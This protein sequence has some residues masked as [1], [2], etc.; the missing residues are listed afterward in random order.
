MA[1]KQPN[2]LFI[3]VDEMHLSA[4]QGTNRAFDLTGIPKLMEQ[5]ECFE[6]VYSCSPV[7][8]PARCSWISG[9]YPHNTGCISNTFGAS[10]PKSETNLFQYLNQ[11]GYHTSL[12]GKCHFIPV[13]YPANRNDMTLNYEHFIEYY[14]SLGIQHLD[15]QDGNNNSM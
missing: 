2:I 13:P 8:L 11:L 6:Q 3:T 10:M 1:N 7:C 14:K 9:K 15:L 5:S 4:I 12:H